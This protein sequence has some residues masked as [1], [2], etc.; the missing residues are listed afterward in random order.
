MKGFS[1][2]VKPSQGHVSGGD[3]HACLVVVATAL[4]QQF[5][6]F[7][8]RL[9]PQATQGL[10]PHGGTGLLLANQ[11]L[12][13]RE[14]M[15]LNPNQHVEV[16]VVSSV[17]NEVLQ[18]IAAFEKNG[19]FSALVRIEVESESRQVP[20]LADGQQPR[21][22][23]DEL[24]DGDEEPDGQQSHLFIEIVRLQG[25]RE[26]HQVPELF[27]AHQNKEQDGVA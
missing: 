4:C 25:A 26:G 22:E 17:L 11:R 5:P 21:H 13:T 19:T 1:G 20:E 2:G 16:L 10:L 9:R 8:N 15:R 24:T 12:V 18:S 6:A 14:L 3:E 23:E 27:V 7:F